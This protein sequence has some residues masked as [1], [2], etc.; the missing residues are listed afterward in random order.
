ME[1]VLCAQ[2][3]AFC[4][5]VIA[6]DKTLGIAAVCVCKDVMKFNILMQLLG[7]CLFSSQHFF[8]VAEKMVQNSFHS[9]KYPLLQVPALDLQVSN[10]L[11]SP[12]HVR[13]KNA[14][15]LS[16]SNY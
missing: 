15:P 7:K 11:S 13:K 3:T 12:Q 14:M 8:R 1:W 10:F 4:L 6:T 16:L 5:S 9:V 2:D